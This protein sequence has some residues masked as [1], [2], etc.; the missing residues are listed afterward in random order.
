MLAQHEPRAAARD[1][2]ACQQRL[3]FAACFAH[4]AHFALPDGVASRIADLELP[5]V[6]AWEPSDGMHVSPLDARYH[7]PRFPRIEVVVRAM[8]Q[9]F[10]WRQDEGELTSVASGATELRRS[11][12]RRVGGGG[13]EQAHGAL[14]S[15]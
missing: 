9:I 11:K 2:V 6:H 5:C 3:A 8:G 14:G 4:G 1:L 7:L 15:I 10:A 12:R 13:A